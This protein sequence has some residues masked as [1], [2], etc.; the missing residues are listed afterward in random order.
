[1]LDFNSN[2]FDYDRFNDKTPDHVLSVSKECKPFKLLLPIQKNWSRSENRLLIVCEHIHSD[3]LHNHTL[4][5]EKPAIVLNNCLDYAT[6]LASRLGETTPKFSIAAINYNFFKS[7]ILDNQQQADLYISNIF[8]KRIRQYIKHINP[9]H[10][11]ISGCEAA[12]ALLSKEIPNID[13]KLGWV[14]NILIDGVPVT[15]THSIDFVRSIEQ[16]KSKYEDD[17]TEDTDDSYDTDV[18][19]E[20]AYLLGYFSRNLRNLLVGYIPFSFK[21]KPH[22][23]YIDTIEKFDDMMDVL[24]KADRV[25]LDTESRNLSRVSNKLY[26]I[27]FAVSKKYGYVVPYLHPESPFNSE[28][29]EYIRVKIRKFLMKKVDIDTGIDTYKALYM[30]NG[31]FDLTLIKQQFCVP[32]IH[33]PVYDLRAGEVALDENIK[34]MGTVAKTK[35]AAI[36]HGGLSQLL[37]NQGEDFYLSSNFSKADRGD[38]DN[39]SLSNEDFLN[40]CS[41]DVQSL[42]AL[43]DN[44]LA[45][46]R[47][48]VH[49]EKGRTQTYEVDFIRHM[50]CQMSSNIHVFSNMEHR[51]VYINKKHILWLKTKDSPISKAIHENTLNMYK[52]PQVIKANKAILDKENINISN[53]L[54]RTVPWVFKINKPEHKIILFIE[55]LGLEPI[56]YGK[57]NTPS[58]GKVFKSVYK[59][60][61]EVAML[62]NLEKAKKLKSS[63]VDAIIKRLGDGDGLVDG[64]LRPSYDFFPVVTGRSNSTDPSLQQIPQRGDNAKQIKTYFSAS[65]GKLLIK[66]DYSAHEIRVWSIISKDSVLGDVFQIGRTLRQKYHKSGKSKYKKEIG[67]KGDIHKSNYNFF[68]GVPVE[69]VT[70]EQRYSV[71]GIGFGAIYGRSSKTLAK[72]AQSEA[73]EKIVS[74]KEK[75]EVARVEIDKKAVA[76]YKAEIKELNKPQEYWIKL[77][78]QL[79]EKFFDRFKVAADWLTKQHDIA[80][81]NYFVKSALG[82]R[83][84]LYGFLTGVNSTIA[85]M[86]RR[87]ANAPIQGMAS[88]I[89]H[90]ASR[91]ISIHIEKVFT[92]LKIIDK[93]TAILPANVEVMVHDSTRLEADF[94]HI[95]ILVHIMQWCSSK[96]VSEYYKKYYDL[97]FTVLPEIEMEFGVNEASM[98]KW[99][100]SVNKYDEEG[101]KDYSLESCLSK[102]VADYKKQYA[103]DQRTEQEI[104]DMIYSV[105]KKSKTY[106]YLN[107]NYPIL[108]D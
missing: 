90:T 68:F 39:T 8:A 25:A 21:L 87:A 89:G 64:R 3:D 30:F 24:N 28:Q 105:W 40:Y 5:T 76:S 57:S 1:M 42:I 34:F 43:A 83:R 92:D 102:A 44:Q 23:K 14:H 104:M 32:V 78:A 74:L 73:K 108:P 63:Y 107:T 29:I 55:T 85:A 95:L 106:N 91:L 19:L 38:M 46:A 72:Q 53:T 88:D 69:E 11:F 18:G 35:K 70:D 45:R 65:Y 4:L 15:V 47:L 86:K 52:S 16:Y 48:E 13:N 49:I 96:G 6:T 67:L 79:Y 26:V 51:G 60:V 17:D 77:Y 103:A 93:N 56:S 98:Y 33:W 22:V 20:G 100:W 7:Y 101:S 61:P 58:L 99:D 75:I 66:M 12:N 82:R 41:F 27:Q 81:N 31:K 9:T 97:T 84:Y 54:I 71:K 36:H 62:N 10:I 50:L 59:R 94:S 2:N 80:S 37:C